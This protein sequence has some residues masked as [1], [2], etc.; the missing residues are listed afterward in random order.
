MKQRN[1]KKQKLQSKKTKNKKEAPGLIKEKKIELSNILLV[2]EIPIKVTPKSNINL[3]CGAGRW[4]K[5]KQKYIPRPFFEMELNISRRLFQGRIKNFIPNTITPFRFEIITVCYVKIS[6]LSQTKTAGKNNKGLHSQG[7]DFMS[8]PR[9]ILGEYIKDR[10]IEKGI[11]R[12]GETV[13]QEMLEEG[14]RRIYRFIKLTKIYLES[15][16]IIRI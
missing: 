11:L 15:Q 14:N 4:S 9:F 10:L 13:T 16:R 2:S 7:G 1:F 12:F 5:R 8:S 6:S 3:S